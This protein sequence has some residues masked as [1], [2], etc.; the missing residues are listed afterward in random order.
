[1]YVM[2]YHWLIVSL[3]KRGFIYHLSHIQIIDILFS[4]AQEGAYAGPCFPFVRECFRF[5]CKFYSQATEEQ[6][7]IRPFNYRKGIL[8]TTLGVLGRLV[9]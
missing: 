2:D 9:G 4:V 7:E 5:I 3:T 8:P 1:M 6:F